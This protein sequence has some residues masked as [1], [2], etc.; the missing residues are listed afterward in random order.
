MLE[1]LCELR[2][3]KTAAYQA[4]HA[5]KI[6]VIRGVMLDSQTIHNTIVTP[7]LPVALQGIVGA[8]FR[9][10]IALRKAQHIVHKTE[11]QFVTMRLAI[12]GTSSG[13]K[14]HALQAS[15]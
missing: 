6:N 5:K 2:L 12:L 4:E 10:I 11:E 13:V 9:R 15:A 8:V 3:L 1:I 7:D 14:L